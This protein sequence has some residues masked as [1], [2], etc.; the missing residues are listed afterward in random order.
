MNAFEQAL[1]AR[2]SKPI[3]DEIGFKKQQLVDFMAERNLAGV[4]LEQA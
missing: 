2:A 3:Q 1:Q 4:L